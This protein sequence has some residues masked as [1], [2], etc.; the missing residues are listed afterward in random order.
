MESFLFAKF[1]WLEQLSVYEHSLQL[2]G[3]AANLLMSDK[4]QVILVYNYHMAIASSCCV[5]LWC[6][7]LLQVCFVQI[8]FKLWK[9]SLLQF[10]IFYKFFDD[11]KLTFG[12]RHYIISLLFSLRS[13]TNKSIWD[14]IVY[15]A[16][17]LLTFLWIVFEPKNCIWCHHKQSM[18]TGNY[19]F[20]S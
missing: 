18:T 9:F 17:T 3:S 5:F 19:D 4:W 12:N 2:E 13:S 15:S 11:G 7:I 14:S 1:P 10:V 20:F 16:L 6:D 8:G